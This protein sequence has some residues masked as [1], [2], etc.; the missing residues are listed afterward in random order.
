MV[1][2]WLSKVDWARFVERVGV[3]A[4]G[5]FAVLWV[6]CT[7]GGAYLDNQVSHQAEQ[8]KTT[9][10]LIDAQIDQGKQTTTAIVE[11]KVAMQG[12]QGISRAARE[13]DREMLMLQREIRDSL[14]LQ[15][16]R[17][18]KASPADNV[19]PAPKSGGS[20]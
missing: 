18:S 3:P 2:G 12:I 15:S 9:G 5:F 20:Q 11:T 8:A 13:S 4:A 14:R 16:P 6:L 19:K 1:P 10:K 7:L 17:P